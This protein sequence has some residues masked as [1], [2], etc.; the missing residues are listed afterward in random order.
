MV[1]TQAVV[2]GWLTRQWVGK[3]R[4]ERIEKVNCIKAVW[5]GYIGRR[6]FERA[7]VGEY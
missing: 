7:M 5:R 4:M 1:L 2:R 3:E 6:T